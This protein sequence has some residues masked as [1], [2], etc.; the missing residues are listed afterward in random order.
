VDRLSLWQFAAAVDGWN[1]VHG[2][3]PQAEAPSDAEFDAMVEASAEQEA[4]KLN[5][6][7][8][9]RGRVPAADGGSAARRVQ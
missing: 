5:G 3:E 1:A 2:A 7:E 9:K 6:K 8:Q 4:R